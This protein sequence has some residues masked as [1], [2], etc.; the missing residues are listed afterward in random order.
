MDPS[1]KLLKVTK[2][3]LPYSSQYKHIL[4]WAEGYQIIFPLLFLSFNPRNLASELGGV[5]DISP[6]TG[7]LGQDVEV[8]ENNGHKLELLLN[9]PCCFEDEI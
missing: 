8:A 1:L 2:E 4:W 3:C 9:A 6:I 7:L 5:C